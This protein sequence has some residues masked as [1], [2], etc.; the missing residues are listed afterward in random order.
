MAAIIINRKNYKKEI[1]NCKTPVLL[2]FGLN[3]GVPSQLLRQTA[4]ELSDALS[5]RVKV[6]F[7]DSMDSGVTERHDIHFFPVSIMIRDGVI[8]DKIIGSLSKDNFMKALGVS[9]TRTSP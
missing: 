1:E 8:T 7:V 2:S 3:N 6:G 5:G 9:S 4:D